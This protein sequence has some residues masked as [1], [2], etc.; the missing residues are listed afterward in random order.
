VTAADL[1]AVFVALA[2]PTRRAMLRLI[3]DAETATPTRLAREFP[4]SRQSV[5]KH[6]AVLARAGLV[7]GRRQGRETR[8]L[9]RPDPLVDAAVWMEEIGARWDGRLSALERH[10]ARRAGG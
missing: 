8:Y 2:D 1:D 3:A 10:L 9:L 6:L 4:V 7:V 5:T